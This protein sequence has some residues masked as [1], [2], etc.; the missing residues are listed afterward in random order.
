MSETVHINRWR[1]FSKHKICFKLPDVIGLFFIKAAFLCYIGTNILSNTK[2]YFFL[3]HE[4]QVFSFPNS[5]LDASTFQS[6]SIDTM[7]TFSIDT[8]MVMQKT[9]MSTE[10]YLTGFF[11]NPTFC[12]VSFLT[13]ITVQ[14]AERRKNFI[15]YLRET[16]LIRF[17][18][19]IESHVV[20]L[21]AFY[22]YLI[23]VNRRTHR[24]QL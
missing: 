1:Q 14:T 3:K 23:W 8:I 13:L 20:Q 21:M 10:L 5:F 6:S 16:V 4:T 9:P 18:Q 7:D 11:H 24:I 17:P 15:Y 22:Q 12:H 2:S 19:W